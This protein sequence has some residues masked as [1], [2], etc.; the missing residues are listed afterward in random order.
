VW[1]ELGV[2]LG[3]PGVVWL[4]DVKLEEAEKGAKVTAVVH[5]KS[6][7]ENLAFDR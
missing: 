7:P 1:I 3:G 4:D 2:G 6:G 5:E